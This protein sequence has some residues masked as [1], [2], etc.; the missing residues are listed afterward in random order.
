MAEK[1]YSPKVKVHSSIF[2]HTKEVSE[3]MGALLLNAS[4]KLFFKGSH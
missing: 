3:T 4:I 2:Y 1:K